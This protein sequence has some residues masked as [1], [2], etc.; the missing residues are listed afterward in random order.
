M[1]RR[2]EDDDAMEFLIAVVIAMFIAILI[3]API[4]M[5]YRACQYWKTNGVL[6]LA[7]ACFTLY[8]EYVFFTQKDEPVLFAWLEIPKDD[9]PTYT[10]GVIL[11]ASLVLCLFDWLDSKLGRPRILRPYMRRRRPDPKRLQYRWKL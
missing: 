3:V 9:W 6:W 4:W 1:S 2:E 8:S 5:L 11:A 7:L 10:G